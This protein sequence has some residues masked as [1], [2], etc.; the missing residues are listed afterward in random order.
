MNSEMLPNQIT[1]ILLLNSIS[2]FSQKSLDFFKRDHLYWCLY[3][4]HNKCVT[5]SFGEDFLMRKYTYTS[6]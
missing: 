5:S 3:T 1:G 4:N 6:I 2:Y